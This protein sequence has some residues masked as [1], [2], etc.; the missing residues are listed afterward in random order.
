[1]SLSTFENY[2]LCTFHK[3]QRKKKNGIDRM[4]ERL[5]NY[6]YILWEGKPFFICYV[7][8]FLYTYMAVVQEEIVHKLWPIFDRFWIILKE[9]KFTFPKCLCS[10]KS[11]KV[12]IVNSEK[13]NI[14]MCFLHWTENS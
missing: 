4:F 13:R 11:L 1:M 2:D 9:G 8:S 6:M 3:K 5:A 7:F 12:L 14:S 10:L